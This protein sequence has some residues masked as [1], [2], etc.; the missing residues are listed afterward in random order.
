MHI[1]TPRFCLHSCPQV[2]ITLLS[3]SLVRVGCMP[4]PRVLFLFL[5][6]CLIPSSTRI[7]EKRLPAKPH[8]I[9]NSHCMSYLQE[10]GFFILQIFLNNLESAIPSTLYTLQP[11][12]SVNLGTSQ[13]ATVYIIEGMIGEVERKRHLFRMRLYLKILELKILGWI[14]VPRLVYLRAFCYRDVGRRSLTDFLVYGQ[15]LKLGELD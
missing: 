10:D 15:E 7:I 12:A 9:H 1:W 3:R 13:G 6:I 8:L 14:F 5:T 2:F 4:S 11:R